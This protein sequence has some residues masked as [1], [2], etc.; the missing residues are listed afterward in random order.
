M[1]VP[2]HASELGYAIA[3]ARS[4]VDGLAGRLPDAPNIS[5]LPL[6]EGGP[7]NGRHEC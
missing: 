1:K 7:D 3:D 5:A 4:A 6:E 2:T